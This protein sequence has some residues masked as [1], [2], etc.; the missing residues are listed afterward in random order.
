[1]AAVTSTIATI[2]SSTTGTIVA[3]ARQAGPGEPQPDLDA[4]E[5]VGQPLQ[6]QRHL[7]A[8]SHP[9]A[10][11]TA[12]TSSGPSRL[13]VETGTSRAIAEPQAQRE[14]DQGEVGRQ[15]RVA[16]RGARTA[17]PRPGNHRGD[18]R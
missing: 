1:M 17:V 12:A 3:I 2:S 13:A 14:H 5:G 16:A 8:P 6:G 9:A 7:T 18:Q 11:T 4:D 15:R 10:E